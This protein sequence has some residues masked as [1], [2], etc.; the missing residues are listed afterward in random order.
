MSFPRGS[1]N[2][3][4]ET[5]RVTD[6]KVL[7]F[8]HRLEVGG[9]QTNAIELAATLRDAHGFEVVL[10]ATP[11]PMVR[12]IEQKGLRFVPAPDAYYHPSWRRMQALRRVVRDERPALI[13]VWDWWQCVDAYYSVHLA[14]RV[15][16]IVS[17]MMMTLTRVLPKGLPTTF[18]TAE[19]VDQA[20]AAGW[21]QASFLP[22]P[23]DVQLNAPDVEDRRRYRA[24][25]GVGE[26]EILVVSVSRLAKGWKS[27]CLFRT[28]DATGALGRDFPLRYVIVGDG[29]TRQALQE[30]ADRVNS[31]LQRPA[32][33]LTGAALDPRP[34][35]AAADIIVGMG[36]SALRAM[37]FGKPVIIAGEQGFAELLSPETAAGF[38][39]R[40]IF[41]RGQ[42]ADNAY[43]VALIR[44]LAEDPR[45]RDQFGAFAREFVVEHFSLERVGATL[46]NLYRQA[47]NEVRP[48]QRIAADGL[49][50]AAIYL[51]ERDFLIPSRSRQKTLGWEAKLQLHS[52]NSR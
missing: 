13:H 46:A 23:V 17:D 24:T 6:M 39:Y 31:A 25:L 1:R 15:P 10:F 42:G 44:G 49:R 32:I 51:R 9:T 38:L 22:P 30:T 36:G 19:N 12:L 45:Q 27:E 50:T 5:W 11:G 52:D 3:R 35:Y 43:L 7:V 26:D 33:L 37:A 29:E 21:R 2:E 41:G 18:G 20:R 47:V 28:A 14:M 16:M 34:A 4:A 40:G 48:M 8:A